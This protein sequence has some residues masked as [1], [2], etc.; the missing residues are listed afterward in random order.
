MCCAALQR[1]LC[2]QGLKVIFK[3]ANSTHRIT[4][5]VLSGLH[6]VPGVTF[7]AYS[8]F[9]EQKMQIFHKLLEDVHH[10][11][12]E[13][14]REKARWQPV[15]DVVLESLQD[16]IDTCKV[17]QNLPQHSSNPIP[18]DL[19]SKE[20]KTFDGCTCTQLPENF[21]QEWYCHWFT[22]KRTALV[23]TKC[24]FCIWKIFKMFFFP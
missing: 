8:I 2:G 5:A 9:F 13:V 11:L 21:R 4:A 17:R 6:S 19:M 12:L 15:P 10:K 3:G 1:T 23:S 16:E 24:R 7:G 20:N 22:K 18:Q 14:E